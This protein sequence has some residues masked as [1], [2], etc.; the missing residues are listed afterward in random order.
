MYIPKKYAEDDWDQ[1]QALIKHYPLATVVSSDLQ[2][3]HFPFHLEHR[4]GKDYLIAHIARANP[5][6]PQLESG[7]PVLVIFK[8]A[9]SYITPLYYPSKKETHKV[10]PTW[11]FGAVHIKGIPK[12]IDLEEFLSHAL[13]S[14]TNQE[15][16]DRQVPW[17][18]S[19]APE[20]YTK[21]MKKAIIGLEIEI[22]SWEAKFKFD[23]DRRPADVEG[24]VEGL[25]QDDKQ[26]MLELVQQTYTRKVERA[27][28]EAK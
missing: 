22:S 11:C 27:A 5:Q 1:A 12:V 28:K 25:K 3:N 6:R 2:A 17:K 26:P 14:L 23:Q 19:D 8:S 18:V 20:S 15:E 24:V 21:I 4:D 10:V 16:H 7:E 13:E 9:D